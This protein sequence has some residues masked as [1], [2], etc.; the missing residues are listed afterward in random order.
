MNCLQVAEDDGLPPYL[1]E[2]CVGTL[3]EFYNFS[4]VYEQS[5]EKLQEIR[6]RYTKTEEEDELSQSP[7]LLTV[8]KTDQDGDEQT[9]EDPQ[10]NEDDSK[11]EVA[12]MQ[13]E[14]G[15]LVQYIIKQELVEGEDAKAYECEEIVANYVEPEELCPEQSD[16][17]ETVSETYSPTKVPSTP[18]LVQQSDGNWY[19]EI[20]KYECEACGDTFLYPTGIVNHM[21]KRHNLHDIN[22]NDYCVKVFIK[23]KN[24]LPRPHEQLLYP[25][26]PQTSDAAKAAS[27]RCQ[28]CKEVFKTPE[29]VKI[30]QTIHKVHVCEVCGA[31]FIKKSYLEDHKEAHGTEKRYKCKFCDKCFKRRTVLVKHKRIHTHPRQ[32]VCEIC[33]KRFNDNGTLKTHT[34]LLHI[35]ERKF[36]CMICNQTFPLKPTLDK[37][38]RRHMKRERGEKDFACDQ[39]DMKYRDKSSLNRHVLTKHSGVNFKVTC[40]EC[41]KQYTSTTNL[42]KHQRMHHKELVIV[43]STPEESL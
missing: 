11:E 34:L 25:I 1:C 19:E 37:H 13:T 15:S 33:G 12:Y 14:D 26:Q 27:L 24:T 9:G 36:K 10:E 18:K 23:A 8:Y 32:C 6:A 7:E 31:S 30:H 2:S 40:G 21:S 35:K 42:F 17:E 38:I 28:I 43:E 39:C 41:G 29:E 16:S 4:V 3:T 5:I 22:C 20:S